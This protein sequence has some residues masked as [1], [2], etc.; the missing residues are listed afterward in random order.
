[1]P[2]YWFDKTENN[3]GVLSTRLGT[4]CQTINGMA[5]T[6]IYLMIQCLSTLFGGVIIA[7]VYEWRTALV[8]LGSLPIL[9][10]AGMV[11]AKFR[12]G[13]MES[14]DKAYKDSAQITMESL[15]NIRTVVS[16]GVENTVLHKYERYIDE[17]RKDLHC[18]ALVSGFFFGLSQVVN[19]V[20][21]GI[22]FFVGTI[23]M[24][25]YGVSLLDVFTAVYCIF[26]AGITIGNN[27]NFMPDINE[28][29][30]SASHIFEILDHEDE[31]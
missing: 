31:I 29:K 10:L 3:C 15:N 12:N 16:F 11:R 25:D 5:T 9:M 20:T 27:S 17:P 21:F 4:D 1:M 24:R 18:S 7:L 14:L 2:I 26:F 8:A 30:L 13:Q 23:F 28:A 6:Y 19:F 22:L